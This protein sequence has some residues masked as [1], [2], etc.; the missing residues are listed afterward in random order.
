M[1]PTKEKYLYSVHPWAD[2]AVEAA[3]L[4][5]QSCVYLLL[6][7]HAPPQTHVQRAGSGDER[8]AADRLVWRA[9]GSHRIVSFGVNGV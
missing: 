9:R 7:N 6:Y 3:C 4:L 1:Y 8:E 2:R 5:D